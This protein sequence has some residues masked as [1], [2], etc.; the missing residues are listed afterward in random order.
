MRAITGSR[1]TSVLTTPPHTHTHT[2]SPITRASNSAWHIGGT[3]RTPFNDELT[4]TF[5]NKG[6]L[7]TAKCLNVIFFI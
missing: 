1:I 7:T 3:Q 4:Y 2:E 6:K 5:C